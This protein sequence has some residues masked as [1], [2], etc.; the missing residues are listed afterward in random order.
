MAQVDDGFETPISASSLLIEEDQHTPGLGYFTLHPTPNRFS[1]GASNKCEGEDAE[2]KEISPTENGPC[3][4]I[5]EKILNSHLQDES[6]IQEKEAVQLEEQQSVTLLKDCIRKT[7]VAFTGGSMVTV[8]L[9]LIP[10]PIPLGILTVGAGMA[11]LGTEFPAA[12]NIL[13]STKQKIMNALR[14]SKR[15]A[16]Q[17]DSRQNEKIVNQYHDLQPQNIGHRCMKWISER[18]LPFIH[19]KNLTD[20]NKRE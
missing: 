13:I 7:V 14:R 10:L 2:K 16:I 6:L 3:S 5:K 12:Q 9:V 4:S 19:A 8:G 15:G 18:V 20:R 1:E 11:V 17:R